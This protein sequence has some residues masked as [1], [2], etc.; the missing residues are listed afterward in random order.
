MPTI[1]NPNIQTSQCSSSSHIISPVTV[2]KISP[3]KCIYQDDQYQGFMNYN[4]ISKLSDIEGSPS[5]TGFLFKKSDDYVTLYKIDFNEKRA[6]EVTECIKIDKKLQVKL[7][8]KCFPVPLPQRFCQGTGCCL[9]RNSMLE[10]FP[11]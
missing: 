10:N 3:R 2:S 8:F 6:P 5:I 1:F 9:T 7:I 4:L 11:V